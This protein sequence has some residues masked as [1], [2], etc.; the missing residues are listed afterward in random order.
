MLMVLSQGN[1]ADQGCHLVVVLA[2]LEETHLK[3]EVTKK[4]VKA[5]V[6]KRKR[7]LYPFFILIKS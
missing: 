7:E 2:V 1:P 5:Q 4:V 6:Q 3:R